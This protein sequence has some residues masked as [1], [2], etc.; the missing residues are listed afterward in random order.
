MIKL[1]VVTLAV[2]ASV[3]LL[4]KA[5]GWDKW[6]RRVITYP[7]YFWLALL[8]LL[9]LFKLYTWRADNLQ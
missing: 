4:A 7:F 1:L 2:W 6:S 3:K 8:L 9:S 5:Y